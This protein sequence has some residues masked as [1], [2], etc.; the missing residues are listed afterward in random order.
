ML[1]TLY[2]SGLGDTLHKAGLGVRLGA[3]I[4][5]AIIFVD[6]LVLISSTPKQGIDKLLLIVARFYDNLKM[7]LSVTKTFILTYAQSEIDWMVEEAMIE[8]VGLCFKSRLQTPQQA[9]LSTAP[10]V[11]SGSLTTNRREIYHTKYWS[12][13]FFKGVNHTKYWSYWFFKGVGYLKI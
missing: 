5:T 9:R 8:E 11:P 3:T 10:T 7:K 2:V 6:E 13:W 4:L 12:Y 1:V